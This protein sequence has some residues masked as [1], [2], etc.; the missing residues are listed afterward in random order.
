MLANFGIILLVLSPIVWGLDRKQ[1]VDYAVKQYT[2]LDK[3]LKIGSQ[4][5]N[6]G[7]PESSTWRTTPGVKDQWTAGF[8]PG[9]LWQLYDYTKNEEWKRLAIK[10]T[11]GLYED[12]FKTDSHDIG[13]MIMCSYGKG[14]EFTA[15]ETYPKVIVTAAH[16]LAKRFSPIVGC[17]RSWGADYVHHLPLKGQFLVIVDNMMNLELL[18]EGWRLSNNQTLYDMAVSH[19]NRTLKE[20]VRHSDYSSYHI[21]AFNETTGAVIR[22]Y[23]GQG[24]NDSS[25]WS[26]GQAWLVTGFTMVYRYTKSQ[27]FLDAAQRLANYYIDHLPADGIAPWDFN[28]PHDK[29]PYIPRDSSSGAIAASG[30]F[31]LYGYTKND[32]YLKTAKLIVESL[33][34][35]RYRADG[36]P[37]YKLP[38]LIVN[39]TISGPNAQKGKSDVALTYGDYYFMNALKYFA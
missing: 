2:K 38:A 27:H 17:T 1:V 13:F 26:R 14:Y 31:E 5:P 25:T 23:Q 11:D 7:S 30:L 16:S 9:V 39:G 28:V 34:S 6:D 3:T 37:A 10:A 24:Y 15:N 32:R 19:A 35:S 33:A 36:N 22:R 29:H 4:Y 8:Y 21:V 12:Q 20:H 18:L